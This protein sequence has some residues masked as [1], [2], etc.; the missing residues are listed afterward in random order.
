[1]SHSLTELYNK[2]RVWGEERG[3][4]KP[5]NVNRQFLKLVEETG[6]LAAGLVK[7]DEAKT[8]DAMGDVFVVWAILCEQL[9]YIPE[10]II[11][12]VYHIINA[13]KGITVGGVFVKYEDMNEEQRIAYD[14]ANSVK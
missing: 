5:E 4:T 14:A 8:R 11:T 6:E 7:Q 13:R 3:I 9:G 10:E 2:I 1:M 12:E